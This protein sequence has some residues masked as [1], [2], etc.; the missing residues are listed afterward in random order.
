MPDLSPEARA[1][2]SKIEKLLKLATKNPSEAEAVAA[3]AKAQEMLAQYNLDMAAV[4]QHSGGK[5]QRSDEKMLGGLYRYQRSLWKA[6]ADLNFCLYWNM[7]TFDPNKTGRSRNRYGETR[8]RQGGWRFEH[9]VVGRTVNVVATRTMAEYLEQVIE[10]ITRER[11]H[12]EGIQFFSKWAV[13]FREGMSDRIEN[14][15]YERR[16]HLL[17]EERRKDQEEKDKTTKAGREGVSTATGL[18]LMVY[19]DK[20]ADANIDFIHGEGTAANW[21]ADRAARSAK[22]KAEQ[23]AYTLWAKEHPE[24]AKAEEE[25]RRKTARRTSWNAGMAQDKRDQGGYYAGYDAAEKV[26]IDPQVSTPVAGRLK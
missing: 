24:E 5:S 14:K 26:S 21:A 9:R 15:I 7:Y 4:E 13:S 8:K 12:G 23:E 22:R 2:V 17:A 25:R 3:A 18:S 1:A 10:R 11:L 6:V 19:I 16:R 20:E